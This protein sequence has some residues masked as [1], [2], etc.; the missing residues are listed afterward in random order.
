MAQ[1]KAKRAAGRK[2]KKDADKAG[3][4]AADKGH[5]TPEAADANDG[6]KQEGVDAAAK[7]ESVEVGAAMRADALQAS[8]MEVGRPADMATPAEDSAAA[9]QEAGSTAG[10]A[11]AGAAV[12]SVADAEKTAAQPTDVVAASKEVRHMHH[13]QDLALDLHGIWTNSEGLK[14]QEDV[15]MLDAETANG[16][17]DISASAQ[18]AGDALPV[19]EAAQPSVA[20]AGVAYQPDDRAVQPADKVPAAAEAQAGGAAK[21]AGG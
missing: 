7:E 13:F 4:G 19:K 8:Q 20:V 2:A 14:V 10:P 3:K 18:P 5:T 11:A 16:T 1:A 6:T 17:H 15:A 9:R 21:D 12:P